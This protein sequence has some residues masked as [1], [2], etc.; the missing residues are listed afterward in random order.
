MFARDKVFLLIVAASMALVPAIAFGQA[1][2]FVTAWGGFG[3]GDGQFQGPTSV[4]VDGI[5][6]VFVA[7]PGDLNNPP[8]TNRIQKFSNTGGYLTQ[9][10]STGNA[11]GQFNQ[12]VGVTVDGSGNV[13]VADYK[14]Y[15]V[16][17]FNSVGGYLAQWSTG[18]N[19]PPSAVAVGPDGGTYTTDP[20]NSGVQR[21]T[22][23]GSP[24]TPLGTPGQDFYSAIGVTVDALN[25][26]YVVD[27]GNNRI[28]VYR[29]STGE[30]VM[31][32]GG[33]NLPYALA[34]GPNGEI[35]IA[36]THG[37][38]VVKFAPITTAAHAATWG[39]V[40]ALYR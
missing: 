7:D 21:F 16:Q 27:T 8:T 24:L 28:A 18:A 38:N 37:N 2:A 1:P 34:V 15:R 36:D 25:F 32:W 29:G 5:G 9:W 6:N 17:K 40:K 14:N 12:P 35:Y 19:R 13:Y 22:S 30:L 20:V 4:A 10:G 26:V 3:T 31:R 33:F 11:N 23:T 39:A